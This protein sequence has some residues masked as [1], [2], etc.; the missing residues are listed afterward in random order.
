LRAFKTLLLR[1]RPALQRAGRLLL[2]FGLAVAPG[3]RVLAHEIPSEIVLHAFAK[4]EDG[5][6][7]LLVRVP[8]VLLQDLDLPKRGPGYLDLASVAAQFQAAATATARYIVLY[9]NEAPLTPRLVE[10]RIS[11]PSDRSFGAYASALA[12]IAGPKLAE[13]SNIFWGQAYFDAHLEH[14]IGSERS[15]FSLELRLGM[16]GL[17][18]FVQYLPP[19]AP[20]RAFELHGGAGRVMLDPRWYQAAAT[21]LASGF[22]HI[23]AGADHLLFLLCLV[24]PYRRLGWSLV[25]VITSF[26]VAHSITL[27]AAARGMVPSGSWFPPLVEVLIAASILYMALENIVRP[28]LRSRWLITGLFG[29]VHGFGFAFLLREQFQ[30]AGQHFLLSLLAFNI[31]IE[32]GQL[33]FIG[34]AIPVLFFL[35]DKLHLDARF[36]SI[37]VSA[38]IAHSAWHWLAERSE[39]L[40]KQPAPQVEIAQ[41]A[42]WLV[43]GAAFALLGWALLG[44]RLGRMAVLRRSDAEASVK[45][46]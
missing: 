1:A 8:L 26:T 20:A 5:R 21:F 29:L 39:Q 44:P 2:A 13:S 46:H 27:I 3:A 41:L 12:S 32:L 30:F 45:P 18:L 38:F 14:P 15:D 23:L 16:R 37:V 31:G 6:L 35:K 19:E 22:R 7:H 24:L 40:A 33:V 10:A 9:E 36:T 17:K 28:N 25:A 43:L 4:P 11:E 34:A 42:P